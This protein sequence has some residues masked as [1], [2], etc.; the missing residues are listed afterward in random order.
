M[1]LLTP[2]LHVVLQSCYMR[3]AE[4]DYLFALRNL[5]SFLTAL[6]DLKVGHCKGAST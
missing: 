4:Q 6:R 3:F 1:F 5:C 2:G